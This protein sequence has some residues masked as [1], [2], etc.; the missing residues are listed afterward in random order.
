MKL[1]TW[2]FVRRAD[3]TY[4]I[5]HRDELVSDSIPEKWLEQELC[6]RHGFCGPEYANILTKLRESGRCRVIL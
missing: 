4:A 3:G 5:F 6:S 2:E 1:N